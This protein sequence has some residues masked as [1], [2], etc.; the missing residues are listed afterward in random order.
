[1]VKSIITRLL[2]W[3]KIEKLPLLDHGGPEIKFAISRIT[4]VILKNYWENDP[5]NGENGIFNAF[6]SHVSSARILQWH[7]CIQNEVKYHECS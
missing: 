5:F 4:E 1:M 6:L 7:R 2:R 3:P